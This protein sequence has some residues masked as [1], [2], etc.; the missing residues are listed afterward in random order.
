MNLGPG[1][2]RRAVLSSVGGLALAGALSACGPSDP[3]PGPR[4]D[5]NVWFHQY[6][7]PGAQEA[8]S[9]Y[10]AEFPGKGAR[11][12]S[13]TENYEEQ[14]VSAL[15]D[16]TGPDVFE[17]SNGPTIDM[18]LAGQVAELTDVLG[19][20]RSDFTPALLD[21]MT[22]QGRVYGIPQVTDT[23]LLVYRRSML[24]QAGV[25]PPRTMDEL[26]SAA[27]V[28]NRGG[29]KGLFLGNSGGVDMLGG[30]LLWSS[31]HEYLTP[32]NEPG[33]VDEDVA[34]GL[35]TMRDLFT[36]GDLL[37]NSPWDWANPTAL[38]EGRTAMQWTGLWA[39]PA[40]VD[41]L[42]PDVGVRPF[43]A[44]GANGG[45]SVPYGAFGSVVNAHGDV[46]R[47]KDFAKWLWVERTDLQLDWAQAHGLHVPARRSLLPLATKLS[48]GL[49][50]EAAQLV[51]SVGHPQTPLLWTRR[52]AAAYRSALERVIRGGE[53][54]MVQLEAAATVVRKEL[55]RFP[56]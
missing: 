54:A 15:D 47:A 2:S 25:V 23:Q 55:E 11:V 43:P 1:V 32:D 34:A 5:L 7:E 19:D 27:R 49:F 8:L 41:A 48:T 39:L 45:A 22:Y 46:S 6:G 21:R 56:R 13:F 20:A 12:R 30:V 28:L 26:V 53:D 18:I 10:A 40:I 50:N 17:F 29:V 4:G 52:S 35:R 31:G 37:L 9:R 38:I 36:S 16:R 33:F 3:T 42:G 51:Y 14:V 24:E 44:I